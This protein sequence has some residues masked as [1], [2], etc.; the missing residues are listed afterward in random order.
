MEI[1]KWQFVQPVEK[2]YSTGLYRGMFNEDVTFQFE[3]WR[4]PDAVANKAVFDPNPTNQ[5]VGSSSLSGHA[6]KFHLTD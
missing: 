3:V 2:R 4:S 1:K 5:K 6:I